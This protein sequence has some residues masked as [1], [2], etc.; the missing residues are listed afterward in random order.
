MSRLTQCLADH[1]F[2]DL[3]R[4]ELGWDQAAGTMT[5]DVDHVCLSFRAIS[6]PARSMFSVGCSMFSVPRRRG[7]A[8]GDRRAADLLARRWGSY[9]QKCILTNGVSDG[10]IPPKHNPS[11]SIP[12]RGGNDMRR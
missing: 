5:V 3:F 7:V 8:D 6:A 1:R 12:G 11:R 9:D 4:D 10:I 2:A